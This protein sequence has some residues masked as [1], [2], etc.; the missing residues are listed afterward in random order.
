MKMRKF[1][2]FI[3]AS[4][5]ALLFVSTTC[6]SSVMSFAAEES[7][8]Q[9]ANDADNG[10]K[11][12]GGYAVSGQIGSVGYATTIYDATNGLPTSDANFILGASDGYVWIGSYGGIIRYDGTVFEKITS[13]EGLTSG[14]G[15]FED[16]KG[17]IW[18][19]TND[20]GV[21]VLNGEK[22]TWITY[23]EGLPASS[24]R[25]F[26][27]DNDGNVYIG[28]TTGVCF[29]DENLTI[30]ELYDARVNEERILSLHNDSDGVIYGQTKNGLIFTI[31]DKKITRCFSSQELGMENRISSILTDPKKDG[32]LYIG[33]EGSEIYY[34]QFGQS[35][36]EMAHISVAPLNSVHW[37]NYDCERVWISSI[38]Q[39]GYLD[40]KGSFN[41][42]KD[43]P[44]DSGIEMVTSDYQGNLWVASSTQGAMKIVT[45]NVPKDRPSKG[46]GKYYLPHGRHFICGIKRG[47]QYPR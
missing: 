45:S 27:E 41:L 17:R 15:L 35:A 25:I 22:V 34:G 2:N 46:C 39:L 44:V 40:E 16:S 19:G 43:L 30:H 1:Q 29:A 33:T 24:I 36:S 12:G 10:H 6:A 28:T 3:A 31:E 21:I 5:G 47:T 20:N 8:Q 18:V 14:R 42:V 23:K 4:L 7:V 37:L 9:E 13:S 26:A 38:N 32:Y 11:L